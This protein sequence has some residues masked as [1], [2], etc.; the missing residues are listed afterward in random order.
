[1]VAN[2]EA[3]QHETHLRRELGAD[4]CK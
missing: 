1:V 2:A 3:A 4:S